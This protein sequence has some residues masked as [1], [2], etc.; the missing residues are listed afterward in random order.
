M[1]DNITAESLKGMTISDI[2]RVV[3]KNWA[4]PNFAAVPYIESM[5]HCETLESRYI[6]EDGATQVVYFLSN[7]TT[8]R[9]DVA[10]L[11]KAELNRR[12]KARGH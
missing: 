6:A 10:K 9:G 1:F 8:W 7:A 11:V 2:S 4:K 3:R 12:L 5:G